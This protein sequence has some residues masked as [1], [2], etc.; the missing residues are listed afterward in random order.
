MVPDSGETVAMPGPMPGPD[1]GQWAPQGEV[2]VPRLVERGLVC[3]PE[4]PEILVDV[5]RLPPFAREATEIRAAERVAARLRDDIEG[6][7]APL[8]LAQAPGDRHLHLGRIRH[9]V[10][11]AGAAARGA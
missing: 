10:H 11:A 4:A 7:A 3:E 6:R 2:G 5:A 1:P 9:V 8:G